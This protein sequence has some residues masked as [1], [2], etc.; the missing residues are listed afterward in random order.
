MTGVQTCA[1]PI[2]LGAPPPPPPP[3]LAELAGAPHAHHKR[4]RFEDDDDSLQEA[5]V[6]AAASLS[7]AAASLSVAAASGGAGAGG[8]GAGGGCVTGVG[9]GAGA[10]AGAKGPRSYPVIPVPSKG[11]FGGVLQKFPGCGGLFPHPYTFPAAAA[12]FGLCHKKEDAGAAAEALGDRKSTRLN[13]S[14]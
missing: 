10:V 8:G 2:L 11:S 13:S 7:A 6:V 1:L 4:P 5:A 9:A 3:P 14:H 12:A